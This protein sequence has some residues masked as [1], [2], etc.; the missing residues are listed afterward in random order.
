MIPHSALANLLASF[1]TEPGLTDEDTILSVASMSFDLSVKELLLPLTVGATLVIGSRRLAADGETLARRMS[2][3]GTT[4]LQATPLT[5]QVLI[6]TGWEG[7]P[8]LIAGCGGEALPPELAVR[9]L[10]LVG[11]LWNFYGPTETTVWSTREL[12]TSADV[13]VGRP[14]ANTSIYV[15]DEHLRPVPI[16]AIGELCIGGAGVAIGYHGKPELT[17][18]RFVTSDFGRIYRTGDLARWRANGRLE[19][20]GR[21]D[22]QI[23]LRGYRIEVGE[24]ETVLLGHPEIVSAAVKV[25]KDRLIAYVVGLTAT[26]AEVREHLRGTLP[27]YM[28]PATFVRLTELP[29][30]PNGK[31]DRLSL[32]E[33][34]P[35]AS[36]RSQDAT[37]EQAA[38]LRVFAEVLGCE[39]GIDDGFFDVGGDSLRAV[40]TVRAIDPELSVLDLFRYPSARS[41][42]E[43]LQSTSP[44]PRMSC[45]S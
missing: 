2:D 10:P 41:L 39:V 9:L 35:P 43:F 40:R 30:T 38:I 6:E 26:D 21:A 5:W 20:R 11:E 27:D 33:P 19:V 8:D 12:I 4:Y 36:I 37:P 42:A 44:A 13:T 23:K 15:L 7:N 14:I 3:T 28:L 34:L 32:P 31:I 1:A 25:W 17:A 45:R 29:T 24:I 22:G 16:G 18:E